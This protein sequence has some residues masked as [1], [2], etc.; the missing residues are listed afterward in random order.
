LGYSV[1]VT[2]ARVTSR[3]GA[4][5]LTLSADHGARTVGVTVRSLSATPFP[6]F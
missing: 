6:A 4:A 2:G 1:T 5:L 3:A